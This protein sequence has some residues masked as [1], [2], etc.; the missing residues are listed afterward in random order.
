MKLFNNKEKLL[1]LLCNILLLFLLCFIFYLLWIQYYGEIIY[2]YRKGNWLIVSMYFINLLLFNK[3]YGGF[4]LVYSK[5]GDLVFSQVLSSLLAN[6][7]LYLIASLIKKTFIPINGFLAILAVNIVTILVITTLIKKLIRIFI[8][9]KNTLL[10]YSDSHIS[11]VNKLD[12]YYSYFFNIMTCINDNDYC[13][14]SFDEYDTIILYNLNETSKAQYITKCYECDK[15]VIIVPSVRDIIMRFSSVIHIIDT[16]MLISNR[17]GPGIWSRGVKRILDIFMSSILLLLTFP[18]VVI[19]AISIKLFDKGPILYSQT[20]VTRNNREFKVYKFRSMKVDAENGSG[21][22][23]AKENDNRI[24]KIGKFIRKTRIDELPQLFNILKGDMSFVG[25]RPER[26]EL[27]KKI[28]E[29]VP[30]FNYR[31]NVKAGLTG[32][33][34]VYGKYNT[35]LKDKLLLDLIYIEN[36]SVLLDI[37]IILMTIKIIFIKDSTE[38]I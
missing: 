23:L 11:F 33:A 1:I 7:S 25:P 37:K 3:L 18:F 4:R 21:A 12:K 17:F 32:Y 34:Q 19:T 5:F 27:I 38:G 6:I 22:Q 10:L 26:P 16:P 30:E 14:Q 29:D 31:L 28:L 36:Y 20:R 35:D 8:K 13:N 24:T 2:F 15:P 9:K